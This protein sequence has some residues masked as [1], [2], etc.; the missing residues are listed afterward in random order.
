MIVHVFISSTYEDL[1]RERKALQSLINR[2]HETKFVGMEDFGARDDTSLKASLKELD[3]CQLYIGIFGARYGSGITEKE[4][5]RAREKGL[6]CR[7]YWKRGDGALDARES[8]TQQQRRERLRKRLHH[9]H[10]VQEFTTLN[11][12]VVKVA[13]DLHRFVF[14]HM[15]SVVRSR[16]APHANRVRRFVEEYVGSPESTVP[17]GGRAAELAQ[18]DT[19]LGDPGGSPYCLVVAPAGR[20]KSALLVRWSNEVAARD[21]R[22]VVFFPISVRFET[23]QEAVIAAHLRGRFSEIWGESSGEARFQETIDETLDA[24]LSRPRPDGRELLLVIDGIDEAAG[25]RPGPHL[26]PA[27]PDDGIRVVVSA[28]A[29]AGDAG[30]GDWR[31]QLGWD[32]RGRATVLDLGPLTRE[33]IKDVFDRTS[34]RD[35]SASS[36]LRLLGQLHRLT[37]GDPLLVHLYVAEITQGATLASLTKRPPGLDAYLRNWWEDQI[38]LWQQRGE[39]TLFEKTALLVLGLLGASLGPLRRD[40][41]LQLTAEDALTSASLEAVL[42]SLSRLVIGDGEQQSYT[43]AHPELARYYSEIRLTE[44]ERREFAARFLAWGRDTLRCVADG[45]LAPERVPV[46][47]VNHYGA[48]L[49]RWSVEEIRALLTASWKNTWYAH[50]GEAYS[51]YLAD[52]ARARNAAR[53]IDQ[54][55]AARD[56]VAPMIGAEVRCALYQSSIHGR[57]THTPV[58]LFALCLEHGVL[59]GDQALASV[60]MLDDPAKRAD[61][62]SQ[63][64]RNLDGAQKRE[65]IEEAVETARATRSSSLL[66]ALAPFLDTL[67]PETLEIARGFQHYELID[68][69]RAVISQLPAALHRQALELIDRL[70]GLDVVEALDLLIDRMNREDRILLQRRMK[71]AVDAMPPDGDKIL[72]LCRLARHRSAAVD[73]ALALAEEILTKDDEYFTS[74]GPILATLAA[75]LDPERHWERAWKLYKSA[76]KNIE[77]GVIATVG[78]AARFPQA[79]AEVRRLSILHGPRADSSKDHWILRRPDWEAILVFHLPPSAREDLAARYLPVLIRTGASED[80]WLSDWS[81]RA[82]L[83]LLSKLPERWAVQCIESVRRITSDAGRARVLEPLLPR[84]P[85]SQRRAILVEE[86]DRARMSDTTDQL[87]VLSKLVR[88]SPAATRGELAEIVRIEATHLP[89]GSERNGVIARIAPWLPANVADECVRE[90]FSQVKDIK[91]EH[92]RSDGLAALVPCLPDDLY[93]AAI[94]QA[95]DLLPESDFAASNAL[96]GYMSVEQRDRTFDGMME[97]V[98]FLMMEMR[99]SLARLVGAIVGF[100]SDAQLERMLRVSVSA[101]EADRA[102]ILAVV[103]AAQRLSAENVPETLTAV[104]NLGSAASRARGL[105]G[106]LPCL[107]DNARES[108]REEAYRACLLIADAPG[109]RARALADLLDASTANADRQVVAECLEAAEAVDEARPRA[110]TF[111]ALVKTRRLARPDRLDAFERMLENAVGSTVGDESG[112]RNR[113]RS[114]DRSFLLHCI[115]DSVDAIANLGGETAVEESFHAI[116]DAAAWWR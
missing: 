74:S 70:D 39:R 42:P 66:A 113:Y 109:M 105:T 32:A 23:N 98:E 72:A 61:G 18:L 49:E 45:D 67:L 78:F 64:I 26:F 1:R 110:E 97:R 43:F 115:A 28:R 89:N 27:R 56:A 21:D 83:Q 94:A 79:A 107:P 112:A 11:D 65:A 95:I 47:L 3:R 48:Y 99:W 55:S 35:I 106:L 85:E 87:V 40:E 59:T 44:A 7:I 57:R 101:S 50:E 82:S 52:V 90:A 81:K 93:P 60:R 53:G 63:L 9:E 71:R 30:H 15:T 29:R 22:A 6:P 24:Y 88:R 108:V 96:F 41:L 111:K 54:R 8:G 16:L 116:R 102:E 58:K 84:I 76:E 4:Y 33:G 86:L 10:V 92:E 12:L 34:P 20:G 5:V 31:R 46:H 73:D 103:A 69:L 2:F 25:W 80:V 104:R 13:L 17:F 51:G 91:H 114:P 77:N 14:E 68:F 62:L 19:W 100:L 37:Q 36:K 38:T 75:E